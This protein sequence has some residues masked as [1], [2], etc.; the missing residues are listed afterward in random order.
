MAW[1]SKVVSLIVVMAGVMPLL[2]AIEKKALETTRIW[3][4]REDGSGA[5]EKKVGEKYDLLYEKAGQMCD[6]KGKIPKGGKGG[7]PAPPS[8]KAGRMHDVWK[9]RAGFEGDFKFE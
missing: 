5:D 9:V 8:K 4:L 6:G 7:F 3:V 1:S 2:L